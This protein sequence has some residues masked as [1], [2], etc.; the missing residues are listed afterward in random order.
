MDFY[1]EQEGPQDLPSD[2]E[3]VA[4]D[5]KTNEIF[6]SFENNFNK[7]YDKTSKGIQTIIN[8]NKDG[9]KLDIPLDQATSEK[10]QAVLTA[11]DNNLAKAESTAASYWET[12]KKPSFWSNITDNLGSRLDQ[13]V[14]LTNETIASVNEQ[15]SDNSSRPTI[16]GNRTD[17]EITELS[18]DKSIYL[19]NN[20]TSKILIDIDSKTEEISEILKDNKKLENLMNELVPQQVSYVTFWTIFLTRRDEILKR[21]EMRKNIL[22]AKEKVEEEKEVGWDDDDE[23]TTDANDDKNSKQPDDTESKSNM[24][25]SPVVITKNDVRPNTQQSEKEEKKSSSDA[26]T[27]TGNNNDDNANDDDDDEDD[28]E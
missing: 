9:V 25:E 14:Q 28:W 4:K 19:T 20:D 18:T 27:K 5:E 13:V 3:G 17:A 23:N 22:N 6:D 7:V 2:N 24:E 12:V 8:D 1:Y 21:E 16:A 15:N 26:P 11:L 10:T